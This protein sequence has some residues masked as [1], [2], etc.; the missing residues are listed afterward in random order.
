MEGYWVPLPE[1]Q[2]AR[3]KSIGNGLESRGQ[4]LR[5]ED[6]VKGSNWL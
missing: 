1:G 4:G 3:A 2:E 5:S 6:V